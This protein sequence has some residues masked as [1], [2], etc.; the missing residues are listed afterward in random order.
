MVEKIKDCEEGVFIFHKIND[1]LTYPIHSNYMYIIQPLTFFK[2]I[3]REM[4][5][6]KI[7]RFLIEYWYVSAFSKNK[8]YF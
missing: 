7:L 5:G 3:C 6:V 8:N 1:E 2:N 4:Q